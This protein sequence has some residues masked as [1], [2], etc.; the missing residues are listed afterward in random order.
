[1]TDLSSGNPVNGD[2]ANIQRRAMMATLA[3][4]EPRELVS[5]LKQTGIRYDYVEL[6]PP[7]L[8]LVMVRGRAGGD[9]APFNLGEAT[10]TRASVQIPS[11]EIGFSY[12]L[13]H[14]RDKARLAAICDAL[15]QNTGHREAV[16]RHVLSPIRA[17]CN[18]AHARETA[19][20]AATRVDFFTMARGED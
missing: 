4:A 14:D 2:V 3:E 1:V 7:E 10:V 20:T 17:R 5:G 13:G 6:R 9:G 11:G 18:V 19:Q 15:W 12:I 16:E 8:G